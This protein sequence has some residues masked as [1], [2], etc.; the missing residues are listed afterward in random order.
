MKAER[1]G[2]NLS[3]RKY[4]ELAFEEAQRDEIF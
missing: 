2:V 3:T 4:W 1:P